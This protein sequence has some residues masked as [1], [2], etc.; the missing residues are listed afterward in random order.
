MKFRRRGLRLPHRKDESREDHHTGKHHDAVLDPQIGVLHEVPSHAC[1]G[2][3][4]DR[5]D[6]HVGGKDPAADLILDPL[7][8]H[9]R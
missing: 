3:K 6:E 2:G 5:E 7:L 1:R 8:H 9:D 4:G